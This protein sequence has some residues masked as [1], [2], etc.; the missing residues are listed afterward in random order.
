MLS[1]TLIQKKEHQYG[2]R[3]PDRSSKQSIGNVVQYQQL[4]QV[5]CTSLLNIQ[6]EATHVGNNH[7]SKLVHLNPK[8]FK[9]MQAFHQHQNSRSTHNQS[10]KPAATALTT[11]AGNCVALGGATTSSLDS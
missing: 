6:D 5:D 1:A 4:R 8:L 11:G 3:Q 9:T 10:K 2:T 7:K